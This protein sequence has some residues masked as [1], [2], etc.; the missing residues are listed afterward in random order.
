MIWWRCA[1]EWLSVRR[2]G[3]RF[4]AIA[5]AGTLCGA[6]AS[7]GAARVDGPGQALAFHSSRAEVDMVH[8]A[9]AFGAFDGDQVAALN[10]FARGIPDA[11]KPAAAPLKV[12]EADNAFDALREFLEKPNVSAPAEKPATPA[13]AP[14]V[15]KAPLVAATYVGSKA[16][17]GCHAN[18]AEKFGYTLMGRLQ[19][20]GKIQCE[21]CHG[22]GSEHVRLGG[23]RGVGGI[24]SF[25]KDDSN[26]TVEENN[27]LCLGCHERGERTHWDG[28][29]HEER[30]LACT[31]CHT[32]MTNVSATHQL[33]T[34]FEPDTCFQCHKD[35]RA[36]MFRS[37]HMPV[38][39]GKVTCSNCHNPH[40]TVTEASLREDSINDN[41]YKCH[42]EKRG[43]VLFEHA[44]VREN[45]LNCH[46]A[47]GSINQFSLKMSLP[48][49][50]YECH[51]IGHAQAG[52]NSQF[53]MSRA[54][55]NCHTNIHGSNSPAG[56]VFQR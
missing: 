26:R 9:V 31:D 55:L 23:G 20:Q 1:G 29:V 34:A 49:L 22:P 28:S 56:A 54:C 48:R 35:R 7:G 27:G 16:C 44:P 18:Q 40:G 36:Q 6:F 19:K 5:A 14:A 15:P 13:K 45:C 30:G 12:A 17:L 3:W 47:H 52:I 37:A 51:T 53:T 4:A 10:N 33:K 32:L 39:E 46:D 21:S 38:R 2:N 25:R 41:C 43:P 24:V 8:A 11:A 42:A 50:C